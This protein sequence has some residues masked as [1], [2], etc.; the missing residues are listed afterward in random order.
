MRRYMPTE[1]LF[2]LIYSLNL[3]FIITPTAYI[4]NIPTIISDIY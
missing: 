1:S 4:K 3:Y 2:K